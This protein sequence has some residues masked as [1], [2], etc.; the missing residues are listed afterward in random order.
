MARENSILE[1]LLKLSVD[2][3]GLIVPARQLERVLARHSHNLIVHIEDESY[4]IAIPGSATAICYRGHELLL[5]TQHQ[6]KNFDE[7][8]VAMMTDT[9]SH[10][11]TSGG[12]RKFVATT[13]TDAHDIVA[14]DFT[15]PC[16]ELPELKKRF[17]HFHGAPPN[18]PSNM[19]LGI[20]AAGYF[21]CEQNYDVQANN[22]LGSVRRTIVCEPDSQLS[23]Q[24]LLSVRP[25]QTLD[26]DPD[27][28]SGG[29]AFVIVMTNSGP[30]AYFAG[31]VVRGGRQYLH[32]LKSHYIQEFLKKAYGPE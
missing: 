22:H 14:F 7:S 24:A 25:V 17:F 6:L 13:S 20:V 26:G 19:I 32:I 28:M 30:K 12:S 21:S 5:A 31:I 18:T 23:D 15:E 16:K 1:Q 8:H 29:S 9:G 4:K 2:V 27:G 10:I 3:N 11:I